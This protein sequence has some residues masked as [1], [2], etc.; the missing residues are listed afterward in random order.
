MCEALFWTAIVTYIPF[1]FCARLIGSNIVPN[2]I[3]RIA[4]L[5]LM[6]SFVYG[7]LAMSVKIAKIHGFS[8]DRGV[9]VFLLGTLL[10]LP[11]VVPLI[12]FFY[13]NMRSL[14]IFVVPLTMQALAMVAVLFI[15]SKILK[16]VPQYSCVLCEFLKK[17]NHRKEVD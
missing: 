17:I 14:F 13:T 2:I 3:K 7:V 15:G 4:F 16:K 8:S 6:A 1:E 5:S 9:S 12:Y 11:I 10:Q